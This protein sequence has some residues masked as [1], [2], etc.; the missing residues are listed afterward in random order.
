MN[1][2]RIGIIFIL[3]LIGIGAIGV[4]TIQ[5][6]QK[7]EKAEEATPIRIGVMTDWQREHSKLYKGRLEG[8]GKLT[9][10]KDNV[11]IAIGPGLRVGNPA[12]KRQTINDQVREITC[13][14]DDGLVG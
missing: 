5:R 1:R 14:T 11:D 12:T 8:R 10:I 2:T 6:A 3:T 4:A 13:G 7:D 9:A